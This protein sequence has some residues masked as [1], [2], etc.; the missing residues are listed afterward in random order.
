[1][2][3]RFF[4]DRPI[5]AVVVS[6]LVTL[7]GLVG[8]SRLPVALYPDITP[9]TVEVSAV[10][11]GANATEV[12]KT[13][14]A[15]IE[16]QINGVEGMISMSSTSG[17]DG[18]YA[19]TVTFQPG[20]DLNIAQVLVQNR[21]N[22]AMP[23]LP[24]L[25]KRRGVLVKK[26]SIGLLMLIN[27]ISPDGS[28]SDLY[29]S[30]YATIQLRDELARLDGVGDIVFLGQRDYSMRVWLDPEKLAI[31]ELTAQ[32]VVAAIEQQN[33]Q[34][35]AGQIGQPPAPA[36]LPFQYTINTQGRLSDPSEFADIILKTDGFGRTVRLR[37]VTTSVE[38]GAVG[39][40][41]VSRLDGRAC[42]ALAIYPLPGSNALDTAQRVRE[43]MAELKPRFPQGLDYAIVYDTTPF[44]QESVKEVIHTL[45]DAIFL[46]AGVMLLFLQNWRSALIPLAAIPV[47]IVGTFGGMAILGYSVNT[48]TL[49]GLVL[50]VGIVV[51]DA[52]VVVEAVEHQISEGLSPRE[53]TIAAMAAVSGPVIA[54]G[55]VLTAVFVP[56]LF[57]TGIIGKFYQQFAVTIAISTLLSAFN[58]LTL[59]PALCPLLLKPRTSPPSEPLPRCLIPVAMAALAYWFVTDRIAAYWSWLQ[60]QTGPLPDWLQ[61]LGEGGLAVAAAVVFGA[62]IGFSLRVGLNR[63]L[64][65]GFQLFHSGFSAVTQAYLA[66]IRGSFRVVPLLLVLYAGLIILTYELLT[67]CPVGFIPGQDKGYLLVSIQLPDSASLSRTDR[68]VKQ[69]SE[70]VQH[71]AGVRH[72]IAVAG[73]SQ[74]LGVNAPNLGTLF[75]VLAPFEARR[76][77]ELS[78]GAILQTLQERLDDALT[79]GLVRVFPAA[80]VEGLGTVGG[81]KLMVEQRANADD[82]GRRRGQSGSASGG[83]RLLQQ[84]AEELVEAGNR[85]PELQGVYT[86]FRAD[87]PWLELRLDREAAEARGVSVGTVLSAL[88][89]YYGSLYVNDFNRFGRT[90]QVN[91]QAD[92]R[93]RNHAD[94]P[95]RIRVPNRNGVMVP[96]GEFLTLEETSGPVMLI[97]HNLYA[98]APITGSPAPGISSGRA[99]RRMDE[100]AAEVLPP[101]MKPAWTELAYM[102]RQTGN[103]AVWA[104]SLSVVLVFLV[105][106]A[107]YESWTLPLAVILVVPICLLSA[108]A[109]VLLAG[110]D[111]NIF[112][113]VGFIVLIGLAC[114][115]AIL[116]VEYARAR[117]DAG[118]SRREATA[119]ACRLRLRPIVMTSFAFIFGVLPLLLAEGAGAEMRRLLG[120]TVFSGMLGV[121]LF[122]IFLTPVFYLAIQWA[123]DRL[124]GVVDD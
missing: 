74:I 5:F 103:T 54:V 108:C 73:Q 36:G 12:V 77:P 50:A 31:R 123:T 96:L 93:F 90:W 22:L 29:L 68:V 40:D 49:F 99:L 59:S 8:L 110:D 63:L 14:A 70:I 26:K 20:I 38:L 80:P 1:V 105:L 119:E 48:L 85:C 62:G 66:V 27:L 28:R 82:P 45:R 122:G 25:V 101:D 109:G 76:R 95:R 69:S 117:R 86:G 84:V 91:V 61:H 19:L 35:A 17:N 55:L 83:P 102:Q 33:A 47:A 13:V 97:R 65:R 7:G 18:H 6:V 100:L 44:I 46:V 87:S 32:A 81:F 88:Q 106:A 10:F 114:K 121:T 34:V 57:V 23:V 107:Q 75:V 4:I 118:L 9:P 39:Y 98:A 16:Q 2:I 92:Q 24:E 94:D 30:N 67:R 43:K 79:E 15:P 60:S 42:V 11:P 52:I 56:C 71:T 51:D 72:V 53:A 111:V 3:A 58:S 104:F 124:R 120:T 37:D 115:N 64:G 112:T 113:Q 116:I 89:I 21:V 41:Q 78:A